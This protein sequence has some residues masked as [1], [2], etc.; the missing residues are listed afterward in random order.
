MT[1][2]SEM[3]FDKPSDGVAAVTHELET[4]NVLAGDLVPAGEAA[5]AILE[6]LDIPVE[7]LIASAWEKFVAVEKA[8]AETR[9]QPGSRQ[10]VRAGHR[11]IQSTQ[12]PRLEAEIDNTS[13]PL[14]TLELIVSLSVDAIVV[15]VAA[16]RIVTVALGDANGE[17]TL[18]CGDVTLA[19]RAVNHVVLPHVIDVGDST[20]GPDAHPPQPPG[21]VPETSQ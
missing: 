10:Q 8:C 3:L 14:L 11:T 17:V 4:A 12:H 13:V 5:A 18:N 16:G 15:T 1:T 9:A 2:V 7:R 21:T 6:L 20:S 19:K